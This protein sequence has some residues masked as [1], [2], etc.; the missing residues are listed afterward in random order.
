MPTGNDC[1]VCG[2]NIGMLAVFRAPVPNRIYCPH[3]RERL[4]YGDTNLMI[5]AAM[6]A[7]TLVVAAS[8][9]LISFAGVNGTE[10]DVALGI[11]AMILGLVAI[12]VAFVCVLWYGSFRLE[13]VNR[14]KDDEWEE[15]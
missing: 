3:C 10:V 14:P 5:V 6:I 2:E 13:P 7:L 1:P 9:W 11:G 12:E 15:F 4:R 8:V